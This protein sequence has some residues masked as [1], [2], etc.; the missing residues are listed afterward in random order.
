MSYDVVGLGQCCI[1]YLGVVEQY[2]DVNAKE[3]VNNLTVQGG[4]PVAT[5]MVTLSRLGA[6]TSF[7]GK[8]SD[9][10]FGSLIKDGLTNESVNIDHLVVEQDKRSQFAFIIIEKGSGKRTVLWSGANVTPLRLKEINRGVIDTAKV[11]LLDGL[12]KE[13]SMIAAQYARDARVKIVVDAGS[14]REGALAL[15]NMSDYFIASEDFA[16][17]YS[18]AN[19]PKAI[20]M[21]LLGLGAKTVIVTLGEKGSICVTP[22][23]YFYQPAFKVKAVDTTGCGDVFHGAFIFGLLQKWDLNETMR[24]AS[25]TAALKCRE[26]GGR[27]AIPDLREV[28][29][30][31]ENDNLS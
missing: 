3:E 25:A 18:R 27:A 26:I 17:Q 29:E 10:Y 20:A 8:I 2:P 9:D 15:I 21:E 6:S 24:F 30:F 12:M 13:S 31:L 14:M 22:E 19:D 4:G 23:K 28:E 16:R 11:L 7:I 5:A 1:D